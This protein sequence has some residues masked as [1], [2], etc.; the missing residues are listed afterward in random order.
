MAR[1]S[2]IARG[3]S[4]SDARS[5]R[6]S[7]CSS[8]ALL[9]ASYRTAGRGRAPAQSST[10]FLPGR[11]FLLVDGAAIRYWQI[12]LSSR[13]QRSLAGLPLSRTFACMAGDPGL[14]RSG[15]FRRFLCYSRCSSSVEFSRP[16]RAVPCV[17]R[18]VLTQP[19]HATIVARPAPHYRS[20]SQHIQKHRV[21]PPPGTAI[22]H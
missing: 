18:V 10:P 12:S 14:D 17:D 8:M 16:A 20:A 4:A 7:R 13:W 5:Q 2:R 11:D 19:V 15:R 6:G 3:D 21:E 1:I 22:V 9:F